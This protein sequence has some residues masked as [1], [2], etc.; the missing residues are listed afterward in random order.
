MAA[1]AAVAVAA[2]GGSGSGAPAPAAAALPQV[3][4]HSKE[5]VTVASLP[6]GT[7]APAAL[8][9]AGEV[10]KVAWSPDGT[11]LAIVQA[12]GVTLFSGAY[13]TCLPPRCCC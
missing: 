11:L 2:A 10:D 8:T 13:V 3:L 5:G 12:S 6:T 7:E 4:L 9:V 1:A